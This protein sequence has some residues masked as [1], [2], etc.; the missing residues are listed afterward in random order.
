LQFTNEELEGENLIKIGKI[1]YII[2]R[3]KIPAVEKE[4]LL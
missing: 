2:L 3:E 1:C 4:V